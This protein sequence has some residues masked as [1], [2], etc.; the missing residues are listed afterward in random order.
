MLTKLAHN[1]I[2]TKSPK[3]M[4]ANKQHRR[5]TDAELFHIGANEKFEL[6]IDN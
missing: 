3:H 6:N 2:I 5:R 1:D 4:A